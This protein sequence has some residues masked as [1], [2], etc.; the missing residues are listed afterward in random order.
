MCPQWINQDRCYCDTRSEQGV[1]KVG[2]IY[3]FWKLTVHVRLFFH[4]IIYKILLFAHFRQLWV[5]LLDTDLHTHQTTSSLI[6]DWT[7]LPWIF[8][9]T[10]FHVKSPY[11]YWWIQCLILHWVFPFLGPMMLRTSLTI[12]TH[13]QHEIQLR[14]Q[15]HLCVCHSQR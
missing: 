5:T 8:H 2:K 9:Q 11:F 12:V 14:E 10:L 4:F 6:N 13:I 1:E 3:I 15:Y 7:N